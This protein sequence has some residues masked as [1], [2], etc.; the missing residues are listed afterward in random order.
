MSYR[1]SKNLLSAC[2]KEAEKDVNPQKS[3][4]GTLILAAALWHLDYPSTKKT[5]LTAVSRGRNNSSTVD[6]IFQ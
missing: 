5:A 2:Y 4:E 6:C 3:D 1:E